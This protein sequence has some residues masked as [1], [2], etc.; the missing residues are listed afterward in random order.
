[1]RRDR[2]VCD[3]VDCSRQ[4]Q[5]SGWRH[6]RFLLFWKCALSVVEQVMCL[7][8]PE[9]DV[10]RQ[11]WCGRGTLTLTQSLA[12][13]THATNL[14]ICIR[15]WIFVVATLH[16]CNLHDRSGKKEDLGS[17]ICRNRFVSIVRATIDSFEEVGKA[18]RD[19]FRN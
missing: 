15:I 8:K 17:C 13:L 2:I 18:L 16:T 12:C 7:L 4:F 10:R 5:S 9:I 6:V 14:H 3:D 11:G 1:M 19:S